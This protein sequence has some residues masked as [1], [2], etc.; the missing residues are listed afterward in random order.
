ML[1]NIAHDEHAAILHAAHQHDAHTCSTLIA[2]HLARTALT[3]L[4]KLDPTHDPI[5]IRQATLMVT[6]P[7][8]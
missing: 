7:Q 8:D 6:G 4:A 2:T 5:I 3:T 1:A